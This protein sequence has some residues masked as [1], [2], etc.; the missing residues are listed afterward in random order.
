MKSHSE[1]THPCPYCE[2]QF[3]KDNSVKSH[4]RGM[5]TCLCCD[6]KGPSD[7]VKDHMKP[8][9]EVRKS[10]FRERCICKACRNAN[11]WKHNPDDKD[12][13]CASCPFL[14]TTKRNLRQHNIQ[15]L[16]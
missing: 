4:V 13:Q 11:Q 15:H 12:F 14:T 7:S 8:I 10:A 3:K 2:K 1:V 16:K 6:F 9:H 5:H